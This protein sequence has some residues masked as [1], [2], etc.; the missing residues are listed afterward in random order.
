MANVR[1][2]QLPVAPDPISGSELVPVVQNGQTVQTTVA[3]IIS[4]PSLTQTFLTVGA[5]PSLPN[6]R[7]IGGGLGIG[8]S[9]AGAQGVYS[10]FLNGTSASLE[11]A[12]TGL[13]AKTGVNTVASRSISVATA[14][15]AIANGDGIAGNPAL[16]LNG[17]A[18]SIATLTGKI[19]RAH[20]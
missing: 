16:S 7:Y 10:L 3:D 12:S 1:I 17:L 19:G 9:D 2:S 8:T 15:L 4:S 14:G 11:N 6:S 13:I 20:V 5:Q 18:L